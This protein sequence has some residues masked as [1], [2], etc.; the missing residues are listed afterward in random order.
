MVKDLALSTL[1]H[2]FG[3]GTSD[4][5]GL[6]KILKQFFF[7]LKKGYFWSRAVGKKFGKS[8]GGGKCTKLT[9][10]LGEN[11]LSGVKFWGGEPWKT[12]SKKS[13]GARQ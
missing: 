4:A 6:A 3:L 9:G 13:A 7:F 11:G 8:V 10:K 12:E 1:W 2:G 5:T